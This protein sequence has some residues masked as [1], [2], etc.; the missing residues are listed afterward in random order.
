MKK[1]L[2]ALVFA[3][4]L[5]FAGDIAITSGGSG[6]ITMSGT[7]GGSGGAASELSTQVALSSGTTGQLD[8][9]RI[10]GVVD[11]STGTNVAVT[12]PIVLTGDTL[13]IQ[14]I[15]LSSG[16]TG[17]L[18]SSSLQGV[19][20]IS[21]GTNLSAVSP[22]VQ[23]GDALRMEP[24][25]L[26]TGV[27][28]SLPTTS[29]ANGTLG[30]SVMASSAAASVIRTGVT[31]G[32]NITVTATASGVSITGVSGSGPYSSA[33]ASTTV[34]NP[35]GL[36]AST[37]S[38]TTMTVNGITYHSPV[39]APAAG[40]T[41]LMIYESDGANVRMS[42]AASIED[43]K[44]YS[45]SETYT[46]TVATNGVT[47]DS[48]AWS[49]GKLSSTRATTIQSVKVYCSSGTSLAFN[50]EERAEGSENSS[51]TNIKSTSFSATPTSGG[52]AVT[53]FSNSGIAAGASLFFVTSTSASSGV[54]NSVTIAITYTETP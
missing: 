30:A 54:V 38:V 17:N 13:S 16:V 32:A 24:I 5:S 12:A 7:G 37:M 50:I 20:D 42:T 10:N 43:G 41:G 26:S 14:Q 25:S 6:T 39:V 49:I 1:L 46:V 4:A 34:S 28:G 35:F 19:V 18:P 9:S 51:G 53:V 48:L 23:D 2:F 47:W 21:T 36:S 22:I 29:I 33:I 40:T 27:T 52:T 3:P 31:A 45:S 8:I 11:F 44:R 15:S